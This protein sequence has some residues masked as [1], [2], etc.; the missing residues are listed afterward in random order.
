MSVGYLVQEFKIKE[1]WSVLMCKLS[2]SRSLDL[3]QTI[4]QKETCVRRLACSR[5]QRSRKMECANEKN[6]K[7]PKYGIHLDNSSK[8]TC[9]GKLSCSGIQ[10]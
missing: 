2:K 4:N 6:P 10:H 8:G 3:I 1:K 7:V 9:F 5:V